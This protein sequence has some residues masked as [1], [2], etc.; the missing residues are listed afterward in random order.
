M[1]QLTELELL[2]LSSDRITNDEIRV[3]VTTT[4]PDGSIR[5]ICF[6]SVDCQSPGAPDILT[7]SVTRHNLRIWFEHGELRMTEVIM[8]ALDIVNE[9]GIDIGTGRT[10]ISLGV[11]KELLGAETGSCA[12]AIAMRYDMRG[13]KSLEI[14]G[15]VTLTPSP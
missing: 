5:T 2:H 15:G 4:L 11:I 9:H 3:V 13:D 7:Y 6:T 12:N 10:L 14:L 8:C 1:K